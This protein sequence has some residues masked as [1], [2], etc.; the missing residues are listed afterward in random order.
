MRI[1]VTG[2][3]GFIGSTLIK[4]LINKFDYFVVNVDKLTYAGNEESLED[5]RSSSNY[6]FE[7]VDICNE[8]EITNIFRK[9][10]PNK[11][12]HLAAESHVDRSILGPG[13][14][15]HTNIV[16]TF[17]LLNVALPPPL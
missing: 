1:L 11:V 2:G 9:Y 10:K 16:G 15:I 13:D 8:S 12:M 6:A 5:I 17:T 3:S 14:F 4:F 7:K